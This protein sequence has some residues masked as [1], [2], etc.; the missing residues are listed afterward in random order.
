MD[1]NNFCFCNYDLDYLEQET[2]VCQG[3]G[4]AKWSKVNEDNGMYQARLEDY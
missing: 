2:E 3:C 4:A 1:S